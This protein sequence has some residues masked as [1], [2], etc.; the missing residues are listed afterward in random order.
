M[1]LLAIVSAGWAS[2]MIIVHMILE[3]EVTFLHHTLLL[4]IER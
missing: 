4:G 3:A 1:L 2:K